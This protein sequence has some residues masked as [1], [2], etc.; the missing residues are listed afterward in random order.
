MMAINCGKVKELLSGVAPYD[1]PNP[2][3]NLPTD[4]A[5]VI[6]T[7]AE[8]LQQDAEFRTKIISGFE[9]LMD[10]PELCWLSAYYLIDLLNLE[11]FKKSAFITP[12]L[13]PLFQKGLEKNSS[14]LKHNKKWVGDI[15]ENGIWGD[16]LRLNKIIFEAY[17]VHLLAEKSMAL[18]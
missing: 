8:E 2:D 16:M 11:E 7:M 15:W 12:N 3:G 17:G 6:R 14:S 9:Q 13:I 4:T 10:D 18:E 1:F 5:L